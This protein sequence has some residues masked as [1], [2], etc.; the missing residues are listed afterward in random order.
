MVVAA[1]YNDKRKIIEIIAV[2]DASTKDDSWF[3]MNYSDDI[4]YAHVLEAI[5]EF[6]QQ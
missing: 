2:K 5:E 3:P 4:S 6:S 1:R